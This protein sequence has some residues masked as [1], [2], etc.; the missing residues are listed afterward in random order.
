VFVQGLVGRCFDLTFGHRRSTVHHRP[1]ACT[2][3]K[4]RVRLFCQ[5]ERSEE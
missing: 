5:P 3:P 1:P 4:R 2:L